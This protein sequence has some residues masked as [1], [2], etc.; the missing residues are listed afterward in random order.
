M[1]KRQ[2][3]GDLSGKE[4]KDGDRNIVLNILLAWGKFLFPVKK[5]LQGPKKLK[6]VLYNR[7]VD[8]WVLGGIYKRF[9][10]LMNIFS[11]LCTGA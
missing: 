6:G 3:C 5:T 4:M 8:A 2:L 1:G 10:Y 7:D 11:F 9:G